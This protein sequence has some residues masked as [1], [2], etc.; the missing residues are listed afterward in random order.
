MTVHVQCDNCGA[1][2]ITDNHAYPD[3]IVQCVSEE[4]D[5]PGSVAGTCC[6]AGRTHDEHNEWAELNQDSACRPVTI[7]I[8]GNPGGGGGS[9]GIAPL[10][11]SPVAAQ[12]QLSGQ[13]G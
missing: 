12:A 11:D 9:W 10:P 1:W 5:P 7:T 2:G 13:G 3:H 6:T 8:M 4:G